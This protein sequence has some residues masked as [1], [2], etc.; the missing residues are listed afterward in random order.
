MRF[1]DYR[2]QMERSASAWFAQRELMVRP[3]APYILQRKDAWRDNLILPQLAGHIEGERKGFPLHK[4]VHHGLSSQAM[5]FNLLLP[6]IERDAV[7]DLQ[8]AFDGMPWPEG[9]SI[10][11]EVEDRAVFDETQGQPTSLDAVVEGGGPSLF[12]EAKLVEPGF[13]GCGQLEL[14]E[15]DGRS[16][17]LDH[18]LCPL[19]QKGRRYW[20]RLEELGFDVDHGPFCAL[21]NNYQFFREAA[22]ALHKGGHLVLLI[23]DD[24]PAFWAEEGQRGLWPLLVDL[25]P[26]Q[27]RSRLHRVSLR[28]AV[29]AL[30]ASGRH[31]DWLGGFEQRYGRVLRQEPGDAEVLAGLPKPLAQAIQE[32]WATLAGGKARGLDGG[33][34]QGRISRMLRDGGVP[35]EDPRWTA[36]IEGGRRLYYGTVE[37][38][39]LVEG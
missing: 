37:H 13:G 16:P 33:A 2:R 22:F 23:Q 3:N 15:C 30:R 20:T 31:E 25:A 27:H 17:A 4:W 19:H 29:E 34:I 12:I 26:E 1:S 8:P 38:D 21:A 10:R 7:D 36:V 6:L 39:K 11:L 24:N 5:L 32:L 35:R 14:G 18:A 9:A 28:A